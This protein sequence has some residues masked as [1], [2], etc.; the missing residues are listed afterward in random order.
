MGSRSFY[1]LLGL[2]GLFVMV[3]LPLL[4]ARL[5]DAGP[6]SPLVLL[7]LTVGGLVTCLAVLLAAAPAQEDRQGRR[8]GRSRRSLPGGTV[9][10]LI[11]L[12]V[13]GTGVI[14]LVGIL[15]P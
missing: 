15:G 3:A 1:R 11:M 2:A 5:A 9:L 4:A 10:L 7:P 14:V 12:T 8:S 13:I 6:Q